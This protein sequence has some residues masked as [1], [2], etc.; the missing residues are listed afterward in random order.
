MS[1]VDAGSMAVEAPN[2]SLNEIA[3]CL[4]AIAAPRVAFVYLHAQAGPDFFADVPFAWTAGELREQGM[5]ADVLHVWFERDR[6]A[7]GERLVD[8]LVQK[9]RAGAYHLVVFEHLW[10]PELIGRIQRDLGALVCETDVFAVHPG[11]RVDFLLRHFLTNRQPLLDLVATLQRGDDLLDVRNLV[12]QLADWPQPRAARPAL[13]SH[14]DRA[15]ALRPFCPI[16]DA[17]VIG[18]PMD[19]QGQPPPVR[20]ALDTNSGCPFSADV[21]RNPAFEGVNLAAEGITLRG[22][23]FCPMGADYIALP[24]AQTVAVHLDQVQWYQQHLESLDEIVLRDQHA[25]RYLPE[26]I[27]GAIE[28]GMA[29]FGIL[30]PGRGDAILRHGEQMEEAARLAADTGFWFTIYLVGFESF[31]QPQLDLYNKGVTVAQYAEALERMRALQVQFPDAFVMTAYAASSFILFNPWTTLEDLDANVA[32]CRDHAVHTLA[33]GLST[34]RLRLYPNLP[35]YWKADN[36][37]L[38]RHVD[39]PADRGAAWSGYSAEAAWAYADGRIAVV[40]ALTRRL[41]ALV[42]PT[43]TVGALAAAL[44]WTRKHL[45]EALPA[46]GPESVS[47]AVDLDELMAGVLELRAL[48]GDAP[49]ATDDNNDDLQAPTADDR[50]A[51][52]APIKR[53]QARTVLLGASC[54]NHCRSCVGEHGTF[55]VDTE[56]LKAR[57]TEAAAGGGRLVLAGREPTLVPGLFGLLRHARRSG[58]SAVE[59]LS[60]GRLLAAPGNARRLL[61]AGGTDL[62]FKRHRL[63]DADEDAI[64]GAEGSGRQMWQAAIRLGNEAPGLGWSM[65]LVPVAEGLAELPAMVDRAARLGARAVR[66]QVLAAEL[67]LDRART[68]R[69]AIDA[70]RARATAHRL[71]CAVE[72]F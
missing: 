19:E 34:T 13:R 18:T 16:T 14:P 68:W 4:P 47:A 24:A 30:V 64:T 71:R 11:Q 1:G 50:Q 69:V 12:V 39:P 56:R 48:G 9:L 46:A 38:L 41:Q 49:P 58:A 20:K 37:G 22:C 62:M 60:N 59:L 51:A 7:L 72:G 66:I 3:A 63:E 26:L 23:A 31:S 15:D 67:D 42:R 36:D 53:R 8:E 25:I 28:R 45:P 32:F 52:A 29:P 5:H 21:R 2:P 65:L 33:R 54:N 10:L 40:E 27:G 57:I 35:L 44:R 55:E 17:I 70:A 43:E 61:R 6:P